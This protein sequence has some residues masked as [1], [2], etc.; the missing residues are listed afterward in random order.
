[1][2]I[3]CVCSTMSAAEQGRR[4]SDVEW[5]RFF[6]PCQKFKPIISD[7]MPNEGH[8]I[9]SNSVQYLHVGTKNNRRHQ[10]VVE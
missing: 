9:D 8:N 5:T 2:R 6:F 4:Y 1:M 7:K 3:N 10:S